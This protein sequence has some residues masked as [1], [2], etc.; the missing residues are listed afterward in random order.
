MTAATP[1]LLRVVGLGLKG[2]QLTAQ[3]VMRKQ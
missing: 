3:T 2:R 1:D